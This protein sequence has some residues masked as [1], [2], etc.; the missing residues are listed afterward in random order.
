MSVFEN[1]ENGYEPYD[2]KT[3]QNG[4]ENGGNG[5]ENGGNGYGNPYETIRKRPYEE[6]RPNAQTGKTDT[7]TGRAKRGPF[8][9]RIAKRRFRSYRI[10][11]L[12]NFG[13][14][15]QGRGGA[16]RGRDPS[17]QPASATDSSKGCQCTEATGAVC[18]EKTASRERSQKEGAGVGGG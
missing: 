4:Y 5:Y 11:Q 7:K 17:R 16:G 13:F 18:H 9:Y 3:G 8:S 12:C 10:A 2:T 6:K 14:E 15:V 1:P